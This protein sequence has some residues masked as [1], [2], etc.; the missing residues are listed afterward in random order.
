MAREH[1]GRSA[2]ELSRA[3]C[4]L[5]AATLPAPLRYSSA[6]P[7]AYMRQRQRW[8]LRQM[9]NLGTWRYAAP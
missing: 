3:D 4:A 9:D 8:I 7:S 6:S 1:F 5:I 2:A